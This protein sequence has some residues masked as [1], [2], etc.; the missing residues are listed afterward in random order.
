MI[1]SPI[2][3]V[4]LLVTISAVLQIFQSIV[5]AYFAVNLLAV[6][7]FG[8]SFF[9][10]SPPPNPLGVTSILSMFLSAIVGVVLVFLWFLLGLNDTIRKKGFIVTGLLGLTICCVIPLVFTTLLGLALILAWHPW[11]SI[12]TLGS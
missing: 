7:A 4:R 11:V 12:G 2:N 5:F 8:S 3:L 1:T 9:I 10:N 6:A